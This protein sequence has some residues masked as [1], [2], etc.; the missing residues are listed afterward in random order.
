MNIKR[1][2]RKYF[3]RFEN[4]APVD[5]IKDI[6]EAGNETG[7]EITFM[8]SL[9]VFS[10]IDFNKSI[11]ES[12]LREK[13]FLNPRVKIDFYFSS[14]DYNISFD[15]DKGV[16]EFVE[17]LDKLQEPSH[18]VIYINGDINSI[19]FELAMRWN[20]GYHENVICFTNNIK[21][22][23]GGTH[24]AGFRSAIT[25][26]VNSYAVNNDL[27]KKGKLVIS[28][29]D[30]REGL[31]AILS[32][33]MPDPRFSSQTKDK[34]VSSEVRS[35]IDSC[36]NEKFGQF[37][38]ENPNVA[39]IVIEK[40][41]EGAKARAAARKARDLARRKSE[42]EISNLPGKLSDC[43][44][45][46]PALSEL[47]IVEGASAGGS[48]KSGRERRYQAVLP[49]K[50][51]ILNI[52]RS[53]F[54]KSLA[55]AE[56]G[57]LISALGCG[58]GDTFDIN[59]CRY[60]KII[61]MSDADVD[62]SH[63]RTL[64][65][66]LFYRYMPNL[67][68]KG[69]LYVA[70]PPLYKVKKGNSEVYLKNESEMLNYIFSNTIGDTSVTCS[71]GSI[72]TGNDMI[73]LIKAI[74]SISNVIKTI[75][76]SLGKELAWAFIFAYKASYFERSQAKF[77]LASRE[78]ATMM[79]D[80]IMSIFNNINRKEVKWSYNISEDN[81][82]TITKNFKGVNEDYI[83]AEKLYSMPDVVSLKNIPAN[84]INDLS[85]IITLTKK[86]ESWHFNRPD[87]LLNKFMDIGQKGIVVSRF[88][89]L[90]EMNAGQLWDTT[91][92][93]S[94]RTLLKVI[95]PD[96]VAANE[97][98]SLLMGN[99]VEPRRRFIQDNALNVAHLDI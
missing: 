51:K 17:Y 72:R 85:G 89:G 77:I 19:A 95:V 57:T 39:R 34:L 49:L 10:H 60:H 28:G 59:K 18:D 67:I 7:T 16:C 63:I 79:A 14:D 29:D 35:V 40:A 1:G 27:I 6:G 80:G 99:I 97:T 15:Y 36:V 64:L 42:L 82:I 62:G 61:I 45:K 56:V 5:H 8:P 13:A 11:L 26:V 55:S 93:P 98:F 58:I 21:Q 47:F 74:Q 53:N 31:T 73:E 38:E 52:E 24:L 94:T 78:A 9:K 70:Q 22:A 96:T 65:L 43:Q 4:G 50:G 71:D 12:R 41:V 86:D 44:E 25:K 2:G 83:I 23:D 46:D 91:L 76:N 66:T 88:K 48:T 92:D 37:L 54:Y 69:Y 68:E 75:S 32:V 20:T 84:I 30:V 33:K 90:G 87:R 81:T 3:I